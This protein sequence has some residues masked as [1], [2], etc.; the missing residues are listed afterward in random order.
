M[1]FSIVLI[2]AI[3][4]LNFSYPG[5]GFHKPLLKAKSVLA[6]NQDSLPYATLH[7]YRSYVPK[8]VASTKKAHIYVND[9]LVHQLK[10]NT[11]ASI[12]VFKE[13]KLRV[14]VDKKQQTET[15]IEIKVKFGKVYFFKCEVSGGLLNTKIT[16]ESVTPEIG[17]EESGFLQNNE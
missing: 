13:G 1:R 6:K 11:I 16:I 17:K 7:F 14:A 3:F 15:E 2:I 8:M 10:A 12:N 4:L 5:V 9:S